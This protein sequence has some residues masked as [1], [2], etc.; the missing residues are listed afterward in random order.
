MASM[1]DTHCHLTYDGLRNRV[2]EV[3]ANAHAS[4]ITRMITVGTSPAD[5]LEAIA[6]AQRYPQVFATV[7]LHPGYTAE[8]P[9]LDD[10][11]AKI[12][13]M[14]HE[15]RVVALGE[16]GLDLHYPDPPLELQ[17]A[18]M[19][20]QLEIASEC[21]K[22]IIIHN[23]K[24]TT[25]TLAMLRASGLPGERFV[26]HC[27]TGLTDELDAILDF[28]AMVSFTGVVTFKSGQALAQASLRVPMDRLMVETDAPYLTPEPHRK[29]KINEP[30]YTADVAAFLAR[31]RGMALDEFEQIT[32]ANAT[33]FF[34]LT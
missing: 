23:R 34:G 8:C 27:F 22:P 11:K 21:D 32:D 5:S 12:R 24:A 31:Q 28:G 13:A 30:R 2:E 15:P 17:Q 33:R 7:G 6:I 26:F 29:I 9:D 19:A 20:A 16:L 18:A 10:V 4:G 14:L 25:Q 3:L 1:I